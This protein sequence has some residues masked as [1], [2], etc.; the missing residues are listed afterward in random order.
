[1]DSRT[2]LL[3]VASQVC[4]LAIVRCQVEDDRKWQFYFSDEKK[5]NLYKEYTKSYSNNHI[6][7]NV[8]AQ[9]VT[10]G[11]F[12]NFYAQKSH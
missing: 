9:Y 12:W 2:I 8:S 1:M 6:V 5:L 7:N 4:L 11:S 10:C 3:L